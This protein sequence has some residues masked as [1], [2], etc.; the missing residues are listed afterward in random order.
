[1]L[2]A[3]SFVTSPWTVLG[4]ADERPFTYDYVAFDAAGTLVWQGHA[5]ELYDEATVKTVQL[6]R[7]SDGDTPPL[8]FAYL[9]P[10]I[11]AA[12]FAPLS[13]LDLGTGFLLFAGLL[14][15]ASAASG[16]LLWHVAELDRGRAVMLVLGC[17]GS[18]S[19]WISILIGQVTPI[20]LCIALASLFLFKRNHPL[21]AGL[22]LGVLFVKPHM[23]LIACLLLL[24]TRQRAALLGTAMSGAT[25]GGASLLLV[26]WAGAREYVELTSLVA[27]QPEHLGLSVAA[28]QN[29]YGV[30]ALLTGIKGGTAVMAAQTVVGLAAI[31]L[32][33][34]FAARAR[35]TVIGG[36]PLYIGSLA[37]FAVLIASPHV[38]FYDLALLTVPAAFVVSR[39][40]VT[41][42]P[43]ARRLMIGVLVV[44][45]VV[46]EVSGML[47]G[48]KLSLTAPFLWAGLCLLCRWPEFERMARTAV[49]A[50]S[51]SLDAPSKLAA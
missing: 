30:V 36:D 8:Y 42:E 26:G 43:Y 41:S 35:K 17:L 39:A 34:V 47:A 22:V 29:L 9:Y 16:I 12:A 10:P 25:A 37:A 18:T 44:G 40:Q 7:A 27:R 19:L 48:A 5:E 51:V 23:A 11:V 6:S 3:G 46:V 49:V 15:L 14:V 33:V 28:E 50:T 45:I 21:A 32:A 1:M 24:T 13:A 4:H 38:Q 20:L 2:A 31:F